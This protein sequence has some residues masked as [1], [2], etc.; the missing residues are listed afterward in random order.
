MIQ[1]RYGVALTFRAPIIKAAVDDFAVSGDWTPAAGDVKL[2]KDGANVANVGTL[3]TAVGGTGS[4][5]W[6]WPLSATEMEAGEVLIQVVDSAT[7]AVKDQGFRIRTLPHGALYTGKATAGAASTITI[8]TG[9][10]I[11][12]GQVLELHGGTGAGQSLVV[13]SYVTGT[14]V[15]TLENAWTVQPDSTS[16]YTIWPSPIAPATTPPTVHVGTIATGA[17]DGGAIAAD[18][19][20]KL[21]AGGLEIVSGTIGGTG[22][23][24]THLH[25]TGLGYADDQLNNYLLV[26]RDV[27]T[28]RVY[29][30]WVT[31]WVNS[32]ALATIATLPFTPEDSVDTYRV[33]SI[34]QDVTGG[35]G[36]DAAGVRAAVGLASANLDTQLS[37][38][39]NVVDAILDD[40]GT[41][42]VPLTA[43]AIDAILDE[44]VEGS[45]TMR[46]MLRGFAAALMGKASGMATT[47]AV[48]RDIGDTK[49]RITAT[50][51][52]D[53]NRTAV[54][55]DLT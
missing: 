52:A 43:A 2:S 23:D 40:T 20:T 42:G 30:R 38:I 51:D 4:A 24:A 6:S 9:L 45:T 48:L 11:R 36:L 21:L 8:A 18:A 28:D 10:N 41:A 15:V 49:N 7:K 12:A 13:N 50:V 5:L 22:N 19:V 29:G 32:T 25:L 39:D 54:T 47:N 34:R 37:T 55:L 35:S 31:D 44:V 53:G 14:G 17:I 33:L 26:V 1:G 46:Q 3:P 16:L 27:S